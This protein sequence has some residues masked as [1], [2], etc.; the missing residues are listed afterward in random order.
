[1]V[2]QQ[3]MTGLHTWGV[4]LPV[5]GT[6]GVMATCACRFILKQVWLRCRTAW[7]CM[8]AHAC[9]PFLNEAMKDAE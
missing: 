6:G 5:C 2:Y 7:H 1:M 3:V 4:A 8:A 9:R